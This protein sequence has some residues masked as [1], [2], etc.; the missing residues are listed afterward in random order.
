MEVSED[1]ENWT[2]IEERL[3]LKGGEKGAETITFENVVKARYVKYQQIE[4]FVYSANGAK[5]SGN[6][7]EFEVYGYELDVFANVIAD[8]N[9]AIETVGITE[10]NQEFTDDMQ[11][12]IA[13]L[14]AIMDFGPI[15]EMNFLKVLLQKQTK[16]LLEGNAPVEIVDKSQLEALLTEEV[17]TTEFSSEDLK[18]YEQAVLFGKNVLYDVDAS[19]ELVAYACNLL[20]EAMENP[21]PASYVTISSNKKIYQDYVL[22]RLIDNDTASLTWLQYSQTAGEYILFSFRDVQTLSNIKIYA[23]DAGNDV[24]R[25]GK[26][27]LSMNGTDWTQIAAIGGNVLE[28]L[29]FEATQAKYVKIS[30]TENANYWW[31]ITEVVFNDAPLQD[32]SLLKDAL[33]VEVE[34]SLYTEASY[35]A[36]VQAKADAQTVYDASDSSQ[37]AIDDAVA[38]LITVRMDLEPVVNTADLQALIDNKADAALYTADSY[39][40]YEAAYEAGKTVLNNADAAQS[41]IDIAVWKI[42]EAIDLLVEDNTPTTLMILTQPEDA[43]AAKGTNAVAFIEAQGDGLIYTWY[44]KNPGN[45]KFYESGEAF[46]DGNTYEIPVYGW[47]DGQ[48]VYCVVTAPNGDSVTSNT[49]TISLAK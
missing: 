37:K 49:V 15:E 1:G 32:K 6:F 23:T 36:Y 20:H 41:E 17:N 39:A 42:E 12:N 48:Q 18:Q 28:D 46:A 2:R 34:E 38:A 3:G 33:A 10:N 16:M 7:S 35:A 8:A 30:V 13:K 11:K 5:Y 25:H 27:E 19:A 26:V 44:Y 21:I 24:L 45:V 4:Q 9:A 22:N 31:K 40:G 14:E 29:S 43:I 47:R